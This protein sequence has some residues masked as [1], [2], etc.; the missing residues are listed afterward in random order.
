MN[1][2]WNMGKIILDL[3]GGTGAW[4]KPYKDAGYDVRVITLP[5]HDVHEYILDCQPYGILAAP[6]C[7]MFSYARLTPSTPRDLRGAMRV[8][9][10]C[11]EIIWE[12]QYNIKTTISKRT[13]LKFWAIE[14]SNGMLKYFLGLSAFVFHPYEFGDPYKKSTNLWGWF[15]NPVKSPV[16][17]DKI[18]IS[19]LG[20]TELQ[21]YHGNIPREFKIKGRKD[22]ILRAITPPG[23][24]KAFF[25]ANQ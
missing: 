21:K 8:V 10:R 2:W 23:F 15:C 25:E 4:S 24:A 12:S 18:N 6:P 17:P 16:M 13:P 1:M 5:E 7:D 9:S 20:T 19:K 11:L 22:K 3:C 14:N